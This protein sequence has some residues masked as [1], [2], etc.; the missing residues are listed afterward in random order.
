MKA[1]SYEVH[2]KTFAFGRERTD[3]P[4]TRLEAALEP[5]R[6]GWR[7]VGQTFKLC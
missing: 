6:I 1:N 4:I 7:E 5:E 3:E 2:F